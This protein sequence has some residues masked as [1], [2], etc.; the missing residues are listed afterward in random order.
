[1]FNNKQPQKCKHGVYDVSG[2][3]IQGF[4]LMGMFGVTNFLGRPHHGISF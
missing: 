1:M 4:G 3:G 2:K